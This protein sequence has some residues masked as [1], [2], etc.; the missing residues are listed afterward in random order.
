MAGEHQ[1]ADPTPASAPVGTPPAAG[2]D[3]VS[4]DQSLWQ[5]FAAARN[6]RAFL[7]AWLALVVA[8]VPQAAVGALLEADPKA[9]AFV[10]VAVVPDP[11]R[12]LAPLRPAAEQAIASGRPATLTDEDTGAARMAWPLRAGADSPVEGVVA[13]E[14][15]TPSPRILQAALRELHWAA[16]WLSARL[17]ERRAGTETARAQRLAIAMDLLAVAGEHPRPQAAAMAVVNELQTILSCD[18]VS[19]GFLV[20]ARM[21]PR[22]RLSAI[23]YSAWFKRRT[24]LAESLEAA[25]EECFDQGTAVA[26]PPAPG[27]ERA[28]AVAHGDHLARS[29]TRSILS[30]PLHHRDG[31]AGVLTFERRREDAPFTA[32]DRLIAEAVADLIGPMME[33]K[34]KNRRLL[35]GRAVEGT[36]RVLG[37]LLGQRRLSWKLLAIALIALAVAAATVQGPFRIQAEANLRGEVQRAAAA[38]FAGFV[39]S[40]QVRAGDRVSAG[41]ELARLDDADLQLEELRWRS[42]IDRLGAQ[43]RAALARGERDQVALLEAQIAQ[44]R[45]QLS[46]ASA[47][48]SRTRIIAPIDGLVVAGDLSQRLGAPVQLGEVLFEIAPL[49][50]WRLDLWIDERDLRHTT[51]GQ[52]GRL[53]LTGAPDSDLGFTLTRLTPVAEQR[54]GANTFRAEA[55]LDTTPA[56]LRPGM[57]GIARIDAGEALYSWIWTRRLVD[58]LRRTVWTW[59]P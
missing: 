52:T 46:L 6:D 12:D 42:E 16:G 11:R 43:S 57:E 50:A 27:T 20:G 21:A 37:V 39:A 17:W 1:V 22:I 45:A 49:D 53:S 3:V 35:A 54:E 32:E 31:I 2:P 25:M 23:S 10:T 15:P 30:V 58:W 9:G 28:I 5:A 26:V 18:Q 14:I 56:G 19:L 44:A 7:T 4:L 40:A 55:R 29:S 51:E 36:L 41:A 8:R 13:L 34:R 33:I 48:L 38:P 47:Q 59:Q 24:A